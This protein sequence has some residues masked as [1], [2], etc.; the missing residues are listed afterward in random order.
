VIVRSLISR[1]TLHRRAS[2]GEGLRVVGRVVIRGEGTVRIGRRA[3]LDASVAPID[4]CA[5]YP[6]S[7]IVIGD[8]VVIESGASLEA[9]RSIRVGDRARLERFCRLMDSHFHSLTGD[10]NKRPA[11][12]SIVVEHDVELGASAILVAGA[13][14]EAHVVVCPGTVVTRRVRAH[15]MVRGA[16]CQIVSAGGGT[17]AT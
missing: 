14:L 7:E 1:A 12:M 17:N 10:R 16:P 13:H 4:L 11:P 8:D 2:V 6:G 15:A 9:E 3:V 5:T